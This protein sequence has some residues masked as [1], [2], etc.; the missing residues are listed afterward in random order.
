[1][2]E[3]IIM[4]INE[5]N[6][7]KELKRGKE[8][9]LNYVVDIY[10]PLVKGI[11]YKILN[12]FGDNGLVEEC[13]NDIFVSIW[14]NA[15]KFDGDKNSFK[16]WIAKISK[17]KAIDYY[18]KRIKQVELSK[19]DVDLGNKYYIE[20]RIE[21]LESKEELIKLINTLE[22]IDKDIFL[23]KFFQGMTSKKIGD[24]KGL[25]ETAINNRIYRCRKKLKDKIECI[26]LEEALR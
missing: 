19:S 20:D 24:I 6:Y 22:K 14:K 1:M 7:I 10:L 23:M 21:S 4:K 18:R 16:S 2:G 9:A 11:T 5:G 25:S 12:Q 15:K 13:I 3:I 17:Y 8:D 26:K